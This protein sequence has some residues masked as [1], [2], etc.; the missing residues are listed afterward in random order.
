[1]TYREWKPRQAQQYFDWFMANKAGRLAALD[2][3]VRASQGA[4]NQGCE[5]VLDYSAESLSPLA[6]WIRRHSGMRCLTEAEKQ[7][8]RETLPDWIVQDI[9]ASEWTD[10]DQ[11][12]SLCWDA[13]V[14]FAEALIRRHPQLTWDYVRKPKNA[15]DFNMPVVVGFP[16]D[17]WLEPTSVAA[18]SI[19]APDDPRDPGE[20]LVTAFHNWERS[21]AE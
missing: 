9:G 6:R 7:R 12:R 5:I 2:N 17:V 1:L 21:L 16:M 19:G 10:D 8:Y 13:G 20:R 14:Y 18:N 4:D 15:A 11:T 3:A